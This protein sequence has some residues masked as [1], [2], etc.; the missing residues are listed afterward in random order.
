MLI[1]TALLAAPVVAAV[2]AF[3]FWANPGRRVNQL[4]LVGTLQT[5]AWLTCWHLAV[6]TPPPDGLQW[7]RWTSAVGGLTPL[8]FWIVK[9]S[10]LGELDRLTL[11]WVKRSLGWLILPVAVAAIPFTEYFIPSHST[12]ANRVFGWG[13]YVYMGSEFLFY[14]LLL[15][16]AINSRRTLTGAQRLELQVW[17]GGGCSMFSCRCRA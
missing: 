14:A 17:L 15:F 6:T 10:I 3:I 12:D 13:Y 8:S 2:G 16:T 4:V 1:T 5:A 11:R 7:L 9:E